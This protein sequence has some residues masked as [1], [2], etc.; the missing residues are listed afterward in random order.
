MG[1]A[2]AQYAATKEKQ[3]SACVSFYGGFKKVVPDW[4]N[5]HAPILL[6]HGENDKG[7]PPEQGRDIEKRL[8]ELGKAVEVAVYA[9]AG[10]AFF[11]DTRKE[12]YNATAAADAWQKTVDLFRANVR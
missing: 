2:L 8:R 1:G 5:L 11:N 4:A 10:H 9:G 3:V 6:I 7:V 12:A